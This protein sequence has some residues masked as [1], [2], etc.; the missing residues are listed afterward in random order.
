MLKLLALDVNFSEEANSAGLFKTS[1]PI[2]QGC[3][4]A[5]C[6]VSMLSSDSTGFQLVL[7]SLA[8]VSLVAGE[9]IHRTRFYDGYQRVGL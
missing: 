4:G 9:I 6:A 3:G 2:M 7:L 1:Q 8:A 5:L